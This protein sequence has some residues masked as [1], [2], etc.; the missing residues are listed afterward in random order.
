ME[1]AKAKRVVIKYIFDENGEKNIEIINK[2][3]ADDE[4]I[5][6]LLKVFNGIIKDL[7]EKDN[8]AD[9]EFSLTVENVTK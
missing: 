5:E 1:K 3:N 6:H 9:V 2:D 4:I 7:S 8:L